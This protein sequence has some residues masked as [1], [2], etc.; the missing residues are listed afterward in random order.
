[1]IIEPEHTRRLSAAR[2]VPVGYTDHRLV[3]SQL[4][5]TMPPARRLTYSYR[6]FRRMDIPAFAAFLRNSSSMKT[7]HSDVDA[8]TRQLDADITSGLNRFAPVRIRTRRQGK[9]GNNWL[10]DEA[11]SA[12]KERRRLERRYARTPTAS[13]K[14]A[15]RQKIYFAD[16]YTILY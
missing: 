7:I 13:N 12:R 1:M 8:A 16:K 2:T 10:S 4:N 15:Y 9:T 6:D 11:S 3:T 14:S 5:C